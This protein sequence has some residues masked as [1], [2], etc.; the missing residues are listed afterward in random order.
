MLR[1]IV[2]YIVLFLF[3]SI[4]I[5]T[6]KL[7][8]AINHEEIGFWRCSLF[9]LLQLTTTLLIAMVVAYYLGNKYSD[10]QI[11]K[12]LFLQITNDISHLFETE[13]HV[14]NSFMK[15]NPGTEED[16]TR[17][18]LILRKISNKITILENHKIKFNRYVKTLVPDIRNH[19]DEIKKTITGDDFM[20]PKAFS[21]ESIRKVL[22]NGDDLIFKLDQ[23]KVSIFD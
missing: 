19:F 4:V 9:D 2:E 3:L 18:L 6:I 10:R 1:R 14:W 11:A 20:A 16:R 8:W 12:N 13:S 7:L 5:V 22:K 15:A 23:I 21:E 17:V